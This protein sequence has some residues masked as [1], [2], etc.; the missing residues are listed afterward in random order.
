M[1]VETIQVRSTGISDVA[2]TPFGI[3]IEFSRLSADFLR[4]RLLN[5]FSNQLSSNKK[6]KFQYRKQRL[7][8]NRAA[9]V[10][11]D[12]NQIAIIDNI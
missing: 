6:Q 3:L 4:K 9:D 11:H 1:P 12:V 7:C 5:Q 2:S 8:V 10:V